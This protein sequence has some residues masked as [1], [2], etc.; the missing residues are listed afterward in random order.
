MGIASLLAGEL[1]GPGTYLTGSPG[2]LELLFGTPLPALPPGERG[3]S[4][5]ETISVEMP[6]RLREVAARWL[7]GM[8][9]GLSGRAGSGPADESAEREYHDLLATEVR[10]A[11]AADR[12]QGLANL[13]WLA[14]SHELAELIERQFGAPGAAPAQ[15]YRAHPLVAGLLRRARES[16]REG[17]PRSQRLL[18]DFRTGAEE[19][20]A[21]VRAII[22]DQ[23]A[24]TERDV[25]AFDATRAL[26]AEN[27]RFR[28]TA[29][30]FLEI[31]RILRERLARGIA[32]GD[33]GLRRVLSA[34]APAGLPEAGADDRVLD[35][36]V[37][38]EPVRERLLA[39]LEGTVADLLHSRVLQAERKQGRDWPDLLEAWTD[40]VCCLRR[41]EAV[42]A[43]RRA[44]DLAP[45]NLEHRETRER[46]LEGR[47]L[48]F[49]VAAGGVQS[50]L[51][52]ATILFADIRGFTLASA[53][54]VSEGDLT[55]E[56]YEI[57]DPAAFIV[58]RFGGT[59]D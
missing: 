35:R 24:L 59:V 31:T 23:L 4:G 32:S 10:A 21:L 33:R 55:R 29:A 45:H 18:L 8:A 34:V 53:G 44:L 40:V 14:H 26:V 50:S 51:R 48:R 36:Y 9:R 58:G 30:P 7:A 15:R 49:G 47:L 52:T 13:F 38:A 20:D 41:A 28:I 11:V 3:P 25:R 37:F 46:Y 27:P 42:G 1:R 16:A 57:F 56:L 22:D 5:A 17:L 19:G 6:R 54:H 39:D 12:R 2:E 43:L